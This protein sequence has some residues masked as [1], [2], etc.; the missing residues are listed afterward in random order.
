MVAVDTTTR[1]ENLMEPGGAWPEVPSSEEIGKLLAPSGTLRVGLNLANKLLVTSSTRTG[2]TAE[3]SGVAPALGLQ[4]A[5]ELGVAIRLVPYES[6]GAVSDDIDGDKFDL[7]FLG[8]DPTRARKIAFSTPYAEIPATFLVPEEADVGTALDVLSKKPSVRIASFKNSCYDLWLQ[9]HMSSTSSSN[10]D[11]IMGKDQGGTVDHLG[12][13][14]SSPKLVHA[15]SFEM[16]V[17]LMKDDRADAV[18]GVYGLLAK[19]AGKSASDNAGGRAYKILDGSFM[20]V[21]QAIGV[22][23]SK[24][25]QLPRIIRY[26]NAFVNKRIQQV[27]ERERSGEMSITKHLMAELGVLGPLLPATP[28]LPPLRITVLGCGAMG[29]IYAALLASA[30]NVVS[31]ADVWSGHVAQMTSDGLKVEGASGSRQ[32]FLENAVEDAL[33]GIKEPQDLVIIATKAAQV[34]DAVRTGWKLIRGGEDHA[35]S[36]DAC[37]LLI[38]NGIG[39]TKGGVEEILGPDGPSRILLGIASNFGACM[40]GPGHAEH[41]SMNLICMGEMDSSTRSSRLE[42][43]AS[44]WSQAGFTTKASDNIHRDVWDKLICNCAF[45]ASSAV[46]GFT[47]GQILDCHQSRNLALSCAKEAACVARAK[48]LELSCGDT[49]EDVEAYVLKFGGTVRAAQPSMLQDHLAKRKCEIMA[50]NGA[51]PREAAK[52]GLGA[53]TNRILADL[54]LARESAF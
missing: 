14:G 7:C 36:K 20:T 54:V 53:P 39:T 38:Q 44:A 30:G 51:I 13:S 11:D 29:S 21:P 40:K 46:L 35:Q 23:V 48:G 9:R 16:S 1:G 41:K 28:S 19:E 45:S 49:D 25:R 33:E 10:P 15:D 8:S 27:D 42:R 5:D 50:I 2:G 3:F 26:L 4:L 24:H 47:V 31:A 34:A 43:I 22:P 37:L 18:A 12:R 6:P 17:E 52:V 32:V